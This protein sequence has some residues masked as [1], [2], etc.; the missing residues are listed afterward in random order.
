MTTL[1]HERRLWRRSIRF[2][3]TMALASISLGLPAFADEPAVRRTP[4]EVGDEA[5]DFTLKS[6]QGEEISLASYRGKNNVVLY[7]YPKD[8]T[9]GCTREAQG[10]RDDFERFKKAG[11]VVLGVSVDDVPSHKNFAGK[12]NLNFPILADIGGAVARRYGVMQWITAKRVTFVIG[13]GG[14]IKKV[15]GEVDSDIAGHSK[16]VLRTVQELNQSEPGGPKSKSKVKA[17][18]KAQDTSQTES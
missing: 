13:K 12:Y 10:F 7:F 5:P 8:N 3:V 1:K 6:G 2:F 18:Q 9:P 11:A 17:K 4:L 16:S 15:Y 14:K